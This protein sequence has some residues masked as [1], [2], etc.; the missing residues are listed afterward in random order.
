MNDEMSFWLITPRDP[1]IVRDGRPF[2]PDPGARAQSLPFP[3]PATVAGAVRTRHGE[4]HGGFGTHG[5][6]PAALRALAVR[7]PF[8]VQLAADGAPSLLL[9]APGDALLLPDHAD[10]T[11]QRRW[12]R[13]L[14]VD[15][16]AQSD[17][18]GGLD[19]VGMP[20]PDNAKPLTGSPAF[21][22][23]SAY[24]AWLEAPGDDAVKL[25]DL[26]ISRLTTESR[27]HVRID[28]LSGAADEGFLF[29]TSGLEFT[30][31]P[32]AKPTWR[33][34]ET[35]TL[36]VLVATDA[37]LAAGL[38][39]LGGERRAVFWQPTTQDGIKA[40]P[41]SVCDKIRENKA[42]RLLLTTPGL[43]QAGLLP[44]FDWLAIP[45]LKLA[46]KGAVAS[47]YDVISGWDYAADA[48]KATRRLAPAG[49]V[50]YLSFA[51]STADAIDRFIER[52]WFQPVSDAAQDRCDGFG[53]AVLGVWDGK[54]DRLEVKACLENQ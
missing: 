23:W 15:A 54:Q 38:G 42:C 25:A 8:L 14:A 35:A 7:G 34:H 30:R 45:D 6:T 49:A 10:A 44:R 12:L 40:C 29:Q 52:V 41:P 11:A 36:G 13:P 43:F 28:P 17:F 33:L 19:Y 27:V 18:D 46:I 2:G 31:R 48:A 47:R 50:Y 39:T 22:W 5:V 24:A 26:G 53:V 16:R 51:G 20:T 9:P 3:F 32:V 21:W 1:I 37:D 4:Q